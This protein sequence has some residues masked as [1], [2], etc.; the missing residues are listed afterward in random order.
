MKRPIKHI[1]PTT[2]K[3][4]LRKAHRAWEEA[5]EEPMK[6]FVDGHSGFAFEL[7]AIHSDFIECRNAEH[8]V[9]YCFPFDQIKALAWKE[10]AAD[11]VS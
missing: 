4:R 2:L 3:D 7:V 5:N 10:E 11:D 9:T 8:G 1:P 6:L